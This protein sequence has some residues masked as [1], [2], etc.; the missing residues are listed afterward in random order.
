MAD[1]SKVYK[2]DKTLISV[3][4]VT[5]RCAPNASSFLSAEVRITERRVNV[6]LLQLKSRTQRALH[7]DTLALA[8]RQPPPH[9]NSQ[10]TGVTHKLDTEYSKNASAGICTT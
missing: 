5:N 1:L 4:C 6:F 2:L 7:T 8:D 9:I 3:M 10:T